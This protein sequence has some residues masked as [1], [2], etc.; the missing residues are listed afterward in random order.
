[1]YE[2]GDLVVYSAQKHSG[3]PTLNAESV[4]PEANGEGYRYYVRKY[5]TVVG[6]AADGS[7]DVVTRRGKHRR[8]VSNDP[9]LRR[10]YW[11]ERL[12]F[13]DRFPQVNDEQNAA[14]SSRAG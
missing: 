4:E 3:H 9:L 7:L 6:I 5:W 14:S 12:F 1:M 8:V 11:W 10:A 13:S 2:V